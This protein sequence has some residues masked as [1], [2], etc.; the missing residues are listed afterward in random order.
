[1]VIF[2]LNYPDLTICVLCI[3][4]ISSSIETTPLCKIK[5]NRT[6][7]HGDIAF[8][9]IGGYRKCCH[10]CSLCVDL[11]M[12]NFLHA[13][14]DALPLY[15][16]LKQSDDWLWRYCIL[17]HISIPPYLWG[18]TTILLSCIAMYWKLTML[19]HFKVIADGNRPTNSLITIVLQPLRGS[20]NY[21]FC[22]FWKANSILNY[23]NMLNKNN[24]STG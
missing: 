7:I 8:K 19:F 18:I 2:A 14:S 15:Q 10:E 12:D 9:R 23:P 24:L 1:M 22:R 16:I 6:I 17:C 21:S 11:V 20:T 5:S 13:P 3:A 4:D